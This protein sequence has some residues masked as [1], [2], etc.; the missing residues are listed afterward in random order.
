MANGLQ[1]ISNE[2][3]NRITSMTLPEQEAY[4]KKYGFYLGTENGI[5]REFIIQNDKNIL[6]KKSLMG[7]A[8]SPEE[9]ARASE[10]GL[11]E[12]E[13]TP[14]QILSGFKAA[15]TLRALSGEELS[16]P[17]SVVAESM[18]PGIFGEKPQPLDYSA[19]M[20]DSMA[21]WEMETVSELPTPEAK[22]SKVKE[23]R[24]QPE[25]YAPTP[26]EK[27]INY[28]DSINKEK[29]PEKYDLAHEEVLQTVG[30][31]LPKDPTYEDALKGRS[32]A[33]NKKTSIGK[34]NIIEDLLL[35]TLPDEMKANYTIG[36]PITPYDKKILTE[37][38]DAE[39]DYYQKVIDKN[40]KGETQKV[41]D[42]LTN[43]F[44]PKE[45][46]GKTRYDRQSGKWFNS[47]GTEWREIIPKK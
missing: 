6:T 12:K 44:N 30:R 37:Y 35:Y 27:A 46:A 7:E 32:N 10:Y 45:K 18:I 23:L 25:T 14:E 29:E 5:T 19:A 11:T 20:S 24:R 15:T 47:D 42:E 4:Y 36:Q 40:E 13:K 1:R 26:L 22:I 31:N 17:D 28:R 9:T 8:L 21:K 16:P 2:K 38:Y 34:S 33:M 3:R 41:I 43:A 39:I